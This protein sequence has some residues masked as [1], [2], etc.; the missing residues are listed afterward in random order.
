MAKQLFMGSPNQTDT[1]KAYELLEEGLTLLC[2]LQQPL[3]R[4]MTVEG[5][6]QR[7]EDWKQINTNAAALYEGL[8]GRALL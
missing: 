3:H 6:A 5:A 8:T 7:A 1:K 4:S 2:G